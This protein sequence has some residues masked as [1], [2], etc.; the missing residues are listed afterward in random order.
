MTLLADVL[1]PAELGINDK[2]L[3]TWRQKL[4]AAPSRP[5]AELEREN[6]ALQREVRMLRQQ[7]EVLKKTLGI[8]SEPPNNATDGSSR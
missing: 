7:Q 1:D 5:V 6:L 3:Y 8:L 2:Q 4:E